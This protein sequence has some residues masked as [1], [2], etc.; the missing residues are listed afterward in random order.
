MKRC[1]GI[2]LA[3][4]ALWGCAQNI[5]D[6]I[7]AVER[8]AYVSDQ[9]PYISVLTMVAYDGDDGA[10]SAILANGS[11]VALYDP[12]GTFDHP[13]LAERGDVFY[14]MTPVMEEVYKLYHARNS[15]FVVEQRLAVSREMADAMI[16]RMQAQGP[17]PKMLCGKNISEVLRSFEQFSNVPQTY[18]PGK[19]MRA[20]A[21]VPGVQ[22]FRTEEDDVGQNVN[23]VM[24]E[25]RDAQGQN[26]K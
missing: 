14:G 6:P 21:D 4:M 25:K 16:A 23:L 17:S 11:Q 9:A 10:H 13:S 5:Q 24:V 8:A 7:E 2:C 3:A 18:Y 19:I 15:H 22:T 20:F 26:D 1:V 12:A